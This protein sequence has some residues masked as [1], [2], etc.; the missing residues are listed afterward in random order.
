M[1]KIRGTKRKISFSLGERCCLMPIDMPYNCNWELRDHFRSLACTSY[2][3]MVLHYKVIYLFLLMFFL[4]L[5]LCIC[6]SS[7]LIAWPAIGIVGS[8]L[9]GVAYGF[10]APLIA[11]FK[12]VEEGKTNMFFNCLFDGTLCAIRGSCT[13][14]RDFMDVCFYSYFSVMDDLRIQEPQNGKPYDIRLL[15]L[16]GA[17]VDGILGVMVDFVVITCMAVF[18]SPYMLIRGWH[19]LFHDLIGREGPFLE[20]ICVPFAGLAILLWPVIVVGAVLC[21]MVSSIFL[22]AFAGVVA[23]QIVVMAFCSTL[24]ADLFS[25]TSKPVRFFKVERLSLIVIAESM[26]PLQNTRRP[27]ANA[28]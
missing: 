19:Q 12:A 9:G 27:S 2:L 28:K 7:L 21:S 6:V 26:S 13:V 18:K 14:V 24:V 15:H 4:K 10:L 3:D 8:V 11:T 22:G 20:T 25:L 23:Y 5:V 1:G 16:P 17:I